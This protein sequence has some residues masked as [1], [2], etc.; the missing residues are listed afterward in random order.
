MVTNVFAFKITQARTKVSNILKT[1][2]IYFLINRYTILSSHLIV[3]AKISLRFGHTVIGTKR[4]LLEARPLESKVHEF[5]QCIVATLFLKCA[6]HY[7]VRDKKYPYK[8][9]K[10]RCIFR[11]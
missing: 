3:H 2:L 1:I 9:F 10:L 8:F 5:A 6:N 7:V 4:L 11:V